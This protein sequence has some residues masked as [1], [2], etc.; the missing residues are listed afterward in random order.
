MRSSMGKYD[1][2]ARATNFLWPDTI[3]ITH[4]SKEMIFAASQCT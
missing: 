4:D 1:F 2:F 3:S